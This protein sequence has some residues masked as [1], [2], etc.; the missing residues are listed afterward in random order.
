MVGILLANLAIGKG[1]AI[2]KKVRQ[3]SPVSIFLATAGIYGLEVFFMQ[4]E[5]VGWK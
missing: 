1:S 2:A 5:D 3:P 4:C